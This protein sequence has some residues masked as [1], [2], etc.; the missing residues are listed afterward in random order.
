MGLFRGFYFSCNLLIFTNLQ[1]KNKSYL[2]A[3]NNN[4]HFTIVNFCKNENYPHLSVQVFLNFKQK[5][6]YGI[7]VGLDIIKDIYKSAPFRSETSR[8]P[9]TGDASPRFFCV[10]YS[11][12]GKPYACRCL[13]CRLTQSSVR[14]LC[15][16]TNV[17]KKYFTAKKVWQKTTPLRKNTPDFATPTNRDNR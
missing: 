17:Q 11:A 1:N 4:Y 14:L 12:Y 2:N 9:P 15:K 7:A 10:N 5:K 3:T 13:P 16:Y 6:T 8:Q